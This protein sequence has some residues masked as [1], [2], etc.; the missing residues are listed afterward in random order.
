MWNR[1]KNNQAKNSF[2]LNEHKVNRKLSKT[3][4][5]NRG[6]LYIYLP[7]IKQ[8]IITKGNECLICYNL[9]FNKIHAIPHRSHFIALSFLFA[10]MRRTITL[11]E[12]IYDND[13]LKW[14]FMF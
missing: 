10:L 13:G 4:T 5:N 11:N 6:L 7:Q 9:L 12:N 1:E 14:L 2:P 8:I 3:P